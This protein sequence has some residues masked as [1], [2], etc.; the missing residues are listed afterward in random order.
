MALGFP[1]RNLAEDLQWIDDVLNPKEEV[2]DAE[3]S[4]SDSEKAWSYDATQVTKFM[5]RANK[6]MAGQEKATSGI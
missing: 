6:F 3:E 2:V 4:D 1:S 5:F